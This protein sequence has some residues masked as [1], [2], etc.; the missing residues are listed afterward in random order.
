M[1]I[2]ITRKGNYDSTNVTE[3]VHCQTSCILVVSGYE[4]IRIL[5]TGN[6]ANSHLFGYG[7]HQNS[8]SAE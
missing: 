6:T 4:A 3:I 7:L 2:L 1:I 5:D 8:F